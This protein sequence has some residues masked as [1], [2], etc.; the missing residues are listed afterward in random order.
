MRDDLFIWTIFDHPL[1][2]SSGFIARKFKLDQ[3][4]SDTLTDDTL[5]GLRAKLPIGL[6]CI[7]RDK[8]DHPSVV[9]SWL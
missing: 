6:T 9:E 7:S 8:N 3:P 2:Y 1:D 4:T 5:E